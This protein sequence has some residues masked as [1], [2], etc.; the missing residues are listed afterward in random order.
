MS[1]CSCEYGSCYCCNANPCTC[2]KSQ[3]DWNGCKCKNCNE[4]RDLAHNW[5]DDYGNEIVSSYEVASSY[6]SGNEYA[7]YH[8]EYIYKVIGRYCSKCGKVERY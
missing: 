5:I 8:T 2:I 4:V 7:P 1:N 6:E 3:H